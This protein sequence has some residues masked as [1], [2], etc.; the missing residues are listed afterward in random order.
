MTIQ[1]LDEWKRSGKDNKNEETVEGGT[2]RQRE[3]RV[4]LSFS[5]MLFTSK[6]VLS[7]I[8]IV[9]LAFFLFY[10]D[11]PVPSLSLLTSQGHRPRWIFCHQHLTGFWL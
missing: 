8:S 7:I 10:P 1:E 3:L 11:N 5:E 4:P 2:Q 9:S 6:P